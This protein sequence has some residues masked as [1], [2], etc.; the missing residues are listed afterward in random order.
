MYK[1]VLITLIPK[2]G[3]L[4][5]VVNAHLDKLSC[6]PSFKMQNSDSIISFAS[7]IS[8]LVGVFKSISCTQDWKALIC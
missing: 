4:Q 7:T 2:F 1:D 6:S 5:T 8:N 3:Q